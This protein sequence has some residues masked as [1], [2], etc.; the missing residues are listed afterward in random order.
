[1]RVVSKT[2]IILNPSL[3]ISAY[4]ENSGNNSFT[5]TAIKLVSFGGFVEGLQNKN[6]GIQ[7]G[8]GN[9][10]TV[11]TTTFNN[12]ITVKNNSTFRYATNRIEVE[13]D[14]ISISADGNKNVSFRITKNGTVGS[15]V[16][17]QYVS[18]GMSPITCFTGFSPVTGG[19]M[20]SQFTISKADSKIIQDNFEIYPNFSEDREPRII[21]DAP[22]KFIA[23]GQSAVFY[24][25]DG[26]MLGGGVLSACF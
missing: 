26:E 13:P 6:L 5:G 19:D 20:V 14:L 24:N 21:F 9:N 2:L 1:M 17:Y 16:D 10:G 22:Q 12:I 25:K 4:V 7:H 8:S 11:T 18:S 3:P 23:S 15:G